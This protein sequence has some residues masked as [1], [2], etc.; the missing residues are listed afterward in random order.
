LNQLLD[1]GQVDILI[2]G[3]SHR[4][5]IRF[6]ETGQQMFKAATPFVNALTEG[7]APEQP[8]FST[9]KAK[10]PP[11]KEQTLE[12]ELNQVLAKASEILQKHLRTHTFIVSY[13]TEGGTTLHDF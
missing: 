12:R 11:I 10:G 3:G 4:Q 1:K 8:A 2:E 5:T 13:V 7:R 6:S 9:A